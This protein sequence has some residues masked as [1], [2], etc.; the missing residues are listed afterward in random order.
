MRTRGPLTAL[1]ALS[2]LSML[3]CQAPEPEPEPATWRGLPPPTSPV[4]A[5]VEPLSHGLGAA[6]T[7]T[8]PSP[9]AALTGPAPT[10]AASTP[11]PPSQTPPPPPPRYEGECIGEYDG[12][13]VPTPEVAAALA[14]AASHTYW[15]ASAPEIQVPEDLLRAVAWQES[16]WQS[17]VIACDG[18]VGLMQVMPGTADWM[19]GRFGQSYDIDVY[20]DN[21]YLGATYLAWLTK[22]IGDAHFGADYSLDPGAC[23]DHLDHCL[24]NLVIA[25]YNYGAG[26]VS[27]Y[28]SELG[29]WGEVTIPNPRYVDNVR[30]LLSS[31]ECLSY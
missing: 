23:A 19:N 9:T 14:E 26:E 25:A 7:P 1:A 3:A 20:T 30:T 27:P 22:Y 2:M 21:A 5:D 28:D 24:L 8:P 17:N 4:P 13:A 18:G 16:G 29:Q 11:E 12:E 6:P 10:A 15:P 31:C